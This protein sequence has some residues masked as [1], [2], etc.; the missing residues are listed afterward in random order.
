MLTGHCLCDA[1]TIQCFAGAALSPPRVAALLTV[2]KHSNPIRLG[3]PISAP[4]TWPIAND[5]PLEIGLNWLYLY[6]NRMESPK[7][8]SH[9]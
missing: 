8:Q 4:F 7:W 5:C 6:G 3:S 2:H 9:G 1:G